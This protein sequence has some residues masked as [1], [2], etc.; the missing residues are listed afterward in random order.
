M[1]YE[2]V[3]F[4]LGG[5]AVES[6]SDRLIHQVAQVLGRSFDD[7]QRTVYDD[8]LLLPLELGH[9]KP[10]AYY[11]GLKRK[12]KL[13]WTFEQFARAW[14]DILREKP[15]VARI[16][17]RLHKR[18]KLMALTNT[19]QLHIEYVRGFSSLALFDYWVASCEVG[20]RKPDP[21][22]YLLALSRAGVRPQ[23][24]VYID[25][26]P[27]FVAAGRGAGLTAIRFQSGQQLEEELRAVGLNV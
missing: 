20:L 1:A 15:E 21:Q 13:P 10:E 22:I 8:G 11:E 26:R 9:I 23:A 4:D 27:E 24:A 19:N 12:L 7:I 16:M 17:A 18:H 6:E 14:N 5:V 3:I 25:D 2:L